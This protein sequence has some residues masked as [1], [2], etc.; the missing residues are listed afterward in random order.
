[1]EFEFHELSKKCEWGIGEISFSQHK[2][3]HNQILRQDTHKEGIV[4]WLRPNT[5]D[6]LRK[7]MGKVDYLRKFIPTYATYAST[8]TDMLTPHNTELDWIP[9]NQ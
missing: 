4:E 9:D 2:I 7:L 1:M 3:R 6:Q 5:S 8:L